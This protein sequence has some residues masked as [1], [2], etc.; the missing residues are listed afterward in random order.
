M[1]QTLP[2]PTDRPLVQAM[3]RGARR[4][5]PS[6]G[7]GSLFT[8]YLK[9]ASTCGECGEE[10]FHHRADDAPAYFTIVVVGHVVVSLV[11]TVEMTL[12]PPLW[13]HA[14]LWIPLTVGLALALLSPIK[15]AIIGLQWALRM[16]GFDPEERDADEGDTPG[17]R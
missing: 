4:R 13:L 2:A 7:T 15:G 8:S 12:H 11:M 14:S 3:L 17:W 5:C 10:L 9:T 16:H 1:P 6:C